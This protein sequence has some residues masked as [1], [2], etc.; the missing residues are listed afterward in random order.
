[1]GGQV[2]DG[3]D[4]GAD[5]RT[6][7]PALVQTSGGGG[8]SLS[9]S[10]SLSLSSLSP[11]SFGGWAMWSVRPLNDSVE[12][13]APA[14]SACL[15]ARSRTSSVFFSFSPVSAMSTTGD[16]QVGI[17]ASD[18]GDRQGALGKIEQLF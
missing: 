2:L 13:L 8:V 4:V 12:T 5:D 11:F 15:L 3:V 9:L 17:V 1:M 14:S 18:R 16:G 7:L 6:R 10:L